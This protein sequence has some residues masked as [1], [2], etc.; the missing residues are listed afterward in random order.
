MKFGLETF[1]FC[2]F[3]P[4]RVFSAGVKTLG[5]IFKISHCKGSIECFNAHFNRIYRLIAMLGSFTP[6]S[7]FSFS[8]DAIFWGHVAIRKP[9]D[10]RIRERE[11]EREMETH[12]EV[13]GQEGRQLILK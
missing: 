1:V 4:V 12:W 5:R 7:F 11:R 6:L 3:V 10:S 2:Y 8:F 13:A 9:C